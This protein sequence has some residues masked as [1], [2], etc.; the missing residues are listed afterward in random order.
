M[1]VLFVSRKKN[2]DSGISPIIFSQGESLKNNQISVNYFLVD[3]GGFKGYLINAIRLKRY[4]RNHQIDII[5]AHFGL[6]G[7]IGAFAKRKEKLVISFMGDDILG[8]KQKTFKKATNSVQLILQKVLI[9]FFYHACIVKSREMNRMVSK[10]KATL[11]PNGVNLNVFYPK[12]TLINPNKILILFPANPNRKVKN[13]LLAEKAVQ[14]L[15]NP[16]V[17]LK[18]VFNVKQNELNNLYNQ[19]NLVLL[20]SQHEGSPNVIKEALACNRPIVST[21]VGDVSWLL[22]Q[23]TG[24]FVS[25]FLVDDVVANIKKAID[26][27]IKQKTTNGRERILRLGLDTN[28]IAERIIKLYQSIL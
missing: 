21:N 20:T 26:Y 27:S 22:Q 13:F 14:K 15:N 12:E 10:K 24:C 17:I 1:N 2:T 8:N 28:A 7:L 18:P 19:A 23:T 16:D 6:N 25:N 9:R 5:H 4:L 11:I 3:K